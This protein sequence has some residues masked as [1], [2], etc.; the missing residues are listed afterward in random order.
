[1]AVE[2]QSR[3]NL[4]PP[5]SNQVIV[6]GAGPVGL[7]ASLLLSKYHIQHAL[8]EQLAEPDN[9]PQAHFL[10]CRTMEVLREL[11]A[12]DQDIEAQSAPLDEWRHFVYCTDLSNLP[13]CDRIKPGSAGSLL[14]SVD[15]FADATVKEHSPV[16]VTHFPQHDLVR[17]LRRKV[18]KSKF[19]RFVEGQR[20]DIREYPDYVTV[21]LTD[22][23]TGRRRQVRTHFLI[24]ADGAHSSTRKQLGIEL[25]KEAGTLQHLI[26]VHFFSPQL[27]EWLRSRIPAMLYFVYS[28]TVVAVLVVHALQRGEF[29]AQ[30]P[31]FP[32]HQLAED[33]DE[34]RCVEMLQRLVGKPINVRVSSIRT[35]RM[36]VW[37]ASRFQSQWGR[38]FLIGDAAHQ[39]PPAGGFGMNTGIQDAHNLIWKIAAALRSEN[40]N[41]SEFTERL[42]VSYENERRP[43]ARLNAKVSVQ[44]FE[45]TLRIPSAIGLDLNTANRLSRWI[46]RIPFPQTLKSACFQK[47]MQLGLKQVDWLKS[48]HVLA[49]KRRRAV[50][51]IFID[52]KQQTLQLL[53][54]NQDLGFVYKKGW[55]AGQDKSVKD[56]FDPLKFTPELKRGGR[57]PHFWLTDKYGQ[58]ISVLD[59][60]SLMIGPDSRPCYVMLVAA[61][62]HITSKI[63]NKAQIAKFDPI[64]MVKIA[65]LRDDQ[66]QGHFSF[67]Q[68]RPPF[69]P[70]P[71]AILMRPD[72]HIAWLYQP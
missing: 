2:N 30:I 67:H 66:S 32:P 51:K 14:G 71:F 39:F 10:N 34:N 59:L 42:L 24:G 15:H 13:V 55:L 64:I 33:F 68:K 27:S 44:N 72:G 58:Q 56:Q 57:M 65:E 53:F 5:E 22:C 46:N 45:K 31:F 63:F 21:N 20:A 40:T 12:L 4:Q 9:H 23:Q 25:I 52:A 1:M 26:N 43:I 62:S 7:V 60:P 29:V 3:V 41:I 48:N 36:G 6:V 70:S 11:D 61:E 69:V 54:P 37:E 19:C 8:V 35:W 47:A 17:L 16:Q 49:Q 28:S 50:S 38:C 18:I